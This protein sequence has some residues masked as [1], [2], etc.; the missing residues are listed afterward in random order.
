M[1]KIEQFEQ[2]LLERTKTKDIKKR[3]HHLKKKP[4]KNKYGITRLQRELENRKTVKKSNIDE[5]LAYLDEFS[6]TTPRSTLQY[7]LD[8]EMELSSLPSE[9]TEITE[10]TEITEQSDSKTRQRIKEMK[11][12]LAD[13]LIE[14][15]DF[16]ERLRVDSDKIKVVAELRYKSSNKIYGYLIQNIS[17]SILDLDYSDKGFDAVC[18]G[19]VVAVTL[20]NFVR[21][22]CKAEFSF[23]L[24]N[25]TVKNTKP[26]DEVIKE[27]EETEQL[28][29]YGNYHFVPASEEQ[30][31]PIIFID[32]I[33]WIIE[34]DFGDDEYL[35]D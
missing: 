12:S 14:D 3:L 30:S 29:V 33:E 20:E 8:N 17:T 25:G 23:K 21:F 6:T 18:P 34:D 28:I 9:I 31:V 5:A 27:E 32:N 35:E 26:L 2:S 11:Q 24:A 16:Q 4:H 15:P 13:R 22:T 1:R 10:T 7:V 19:D